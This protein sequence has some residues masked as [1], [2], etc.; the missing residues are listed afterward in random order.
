MPRKNP[1]GGGQGQ[2]AEALDAIS[3][4]EPGPF[5]LGDVVHLVFSAAD[6]EGIV[7]QLVVQVAS[8]GLVHRTALSGD[9]IVL[10]PTPTWG[11]PQPG[12]LTLTLLRWVDKG[13]SGIDWAGFETVVEGATVYDVVV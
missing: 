5:R 2:A 12:T 13:P 1:K 10:G 3:L 11:I 7:G 8:G 9:A 4:L 6:P